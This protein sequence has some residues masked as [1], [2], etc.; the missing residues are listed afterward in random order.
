MSTSIKLCDLEKFQDILNEIDQLLFMVC[1]H[2]PVI[3]G[4]NQW[5][6]IG[7][8]EAFHRFLT[9]TTTIF[10]NF[11]FKEKNSELRLF[12]KISMHGSTKSWNKMTEQFREAVVYVEM[13]NKYRQVIAP[14]GTMFLF[15]YCFMTLSLRV[16]GTIL[17]TAG[18]KSLGSRRVL[19]QMSQVSIL[20]D[21][22]SEAW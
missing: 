9:T 16:V 7:N 17:N 5:H 2:I 15:L 13:T 3:D 10:V 18:S 4:K 21:R 8:S 14:K 22:S 20:E 19:R 6:L 12:S 1:S 11:L